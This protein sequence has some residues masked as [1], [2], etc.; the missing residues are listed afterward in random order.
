VDAFAWTVVGSLAGV[1][2]AAA[3]IVFGVMPLLESRRK[4]ALDMVGDGSPPEASV[5]AQTD[6]RDDDTRTPRYRSQDEAKALIHMRTVS[7]FRDWQQLRDIAVQNPRAGILF[8]WQLVHILVYA[9][10]YSEKAAVTEDWETELPL[11]ATRLGASSRVAA[12]LEDLLDRRDMV[13]DGASVRPS[14]CLEYIDAAETVLRNWLGR[15]ADLPDYLRYD[16][17][18]DL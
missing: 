8:A 10:A 14:D 4:A 18:Q 7:G 17:E 12:V 1:I 13:D 6:L 16:R 15:D 2:C 11:I 5:G 3:A 9:R